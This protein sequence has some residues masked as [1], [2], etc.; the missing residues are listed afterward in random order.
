MGHP[1]PVLPSL[2]A[3]SAAKTRA[4]AVQECLPERT[5]DQCGSPQA[6]APRPRYRCCNCK[7]P[8][9]LCELNDAMLCSAC[10]PPDPDPD[11]VIDTSDAEMRREHGFYV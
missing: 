10:G 4:S 9:M 5:M 7:A 3:E 6:L 11:G 1:Q 2:A 8:A